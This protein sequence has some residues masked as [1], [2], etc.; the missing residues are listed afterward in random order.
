MAV[1]CPAAIACA[2]DDGPSVSRA[3]LQPGSPGASRDP[4]H[5]HDLETEHIF[6]MTSGADLGEKGEVATE[7][8][9]FAAFGKRA[10][11]Y[12]ASSTHALLKYNLTDDFR[13]TPSFTYATHG[14]SAVPGLDDSRAAGISD[15]AFEIRYRLLDRH[16]APF[17]LTVSLEPGIG[18]VDEVSGQRIR[19]Y[20]W[21]LAAMMD[22][23]FVTDRLYGAINLSYAGAA[24]QPAAEALWSH[25]SEFSISVAMSYR[26]LPS[27][28]AGFEVRHLQ[29]CE[30]AGLD[31][32]EGEALFVGPT[33]AVYLTK[34]LALSGAW[35]FQLSGK[36]VDAPGSLDLTNFE[37]QHALL[38]LT[39][40]F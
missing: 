16:V 24:S 23:E 28:I 31:R 35:S 8:E 25:D 30:G 14:I 15:A 26:F 9:S 33:F 32:R 17:G 22:K 11:R 6:G 36:A 21:V 29:A 4:G 7:L 10:G 27:V 34:T 39:A 13:I 40:H 38:R 12:V 19:G 1:L 18:R 3:S 37:R 20:G 5:Q 2:A